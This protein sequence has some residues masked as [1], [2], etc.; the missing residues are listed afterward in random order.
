[1]GLRTAEPEL[2]LLRRPC[3]QLYAKTGCLPGTD[4]PGASLPLPVLPN[5]APTDVLER[6]EMAKWDNVSVRSLLQTLDPASSA[7]LGKLL[8]LSWPP[9]LCCRQMVMTMP[10]WWGCDDCTIPRCKAP[11]AVPDTAGGCYSLSTLH[12]MWACARL[13]PALGFKVCQLLD[14]L[15]LQTWIFTFSLLFPSSSSLLTLSHSHT[16]AHTC[17]HIDV[18]MVSLTFPSCSFCLHGSLCPCSSLHGSLCFLK[19]LLMITSLETFPEHLPTHHAPNRGVS[20]VLM[21]HPVSPNPPLELSSSK[22]F[23]ILWFGCLK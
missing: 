9:F 13:H 16:H 18:S 20:L 17:S 6:K 1:M 11:H 2:E 23:I 10:T 14:S 12:G 8:N 21:T 15:H 19:V 4:S 5:W 3:M 7:A 22:C